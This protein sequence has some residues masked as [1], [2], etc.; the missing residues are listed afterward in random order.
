MGLIDTLTTYKYSVGL[1]AVAIGCFI[2]FVV[3]VND[4]QKK[5]EKHGSGKLGGGIVL[6]IVSVISAVYAYI[7]YEY[8]KKASVYYF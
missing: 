2:G 4:S 3:L 1:I 8:P 5:N 7:W 6:G